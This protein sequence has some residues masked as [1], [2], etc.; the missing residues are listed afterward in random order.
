M[1]CRF[2][3]VLRGKRCDRIARCFGPFD[4]SIELEFLPGGCLSTI[5]ETMG[6]DGEFDKR[7]NWAI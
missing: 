3:S 7:L 4:N 5:L 2:I 1:S 6:P